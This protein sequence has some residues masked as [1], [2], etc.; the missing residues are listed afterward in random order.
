MK[1]DH[2]NWGIEYETMPVNQGESF[3]QVRDSIKDIV[4]NTNPVYI[5]CL[6]SSVK[7]SLD[8][9]DEKFLAAVE[10]AKLKGW[11]TYH[12]SV[13]YHPTGDALG[14]YIEFLGTFTVR[15]WEQDEDTAIRLVTG[16]FNTLASKPTSRLY[17]AQLRKVQ[18]AIPPPQDGEGFLPGTLDEKL[19]RMRGREDYRE[20]FIELEHLQHMQALVKK[21]GR[22]P[23]HRSIDEE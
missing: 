4:V 7:D 8:E 23:H 5:Y 19:D 6:E 12:L 15:L 16:A 22:V 11:Q 20:F 10:E 1:Y 17:N 14:L 9:E 2:W 13:V 21:Y 18:S 3:A